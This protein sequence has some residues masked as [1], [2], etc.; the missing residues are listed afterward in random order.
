[1]WTVMT[2]FVT[3][4]NKKQLILLC[5]LCLFQPVIVW[6]NCDFDDFPIMDEMKV[7]NVMG[8]ANY[9]NRPMMVMSFLA[10]ARFRQVIEYYHKVWDER[11][12]DTA[13]SVWHQVTTIT[14]ECMMTVQI[15]AQDGLESSG[16]LIISN[17]LTGNFNARLG[18]DLLAPT[19]TEVVSD[20]VTNDGPQKGRVSVLTSADSP[21]SVAAFYIS[22]MQ[23]KGWHL[24]RDFTES[25]AH[26]LVFRNGLNI[27]NIVML[28]TGDGK[29]QIL[30]N[31]VK[32]K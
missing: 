32:R 29:T 8:D 10:D 3:T 30:I 26:A 15:A 9:N 1:M 21:S 25:G 11:Y 19:D 16:R 18:A 20:L 28:P 4:M 14:D 24:E 22:E 31:E 6:G 5:V 17:P 12:D 2:G 13:F 27:S 23:N 7:Q